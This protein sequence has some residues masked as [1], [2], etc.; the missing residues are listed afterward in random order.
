MHELATNAV[1]Y[2]ALRNVGGK[3]AIEW[4]VVGPRDQQILHINWRETGVPLPAGSAGKDGFGMQLIRRSLSSTLRAKSEV[5]FGPD[6]IVCHFA[7]PLE[8]GEGLA[9][10][11]LDPH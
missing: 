5:N 1:K 7:I 3:L 8:S 4:Q 11:A 9:P 10:P 6:G 2:G